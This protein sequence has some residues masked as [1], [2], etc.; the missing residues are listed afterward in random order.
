MTLSYKNIFRSLPHNYILFATNDPVYTILEITDCFSLSMGL[1]GVDVVGKGLFDAFP[2]QA[3]SNARL[4]AVSLRKVIATKRMDSMNVVRY[5]LP[6]PGGELSERYWKP[7]N[8]PFIGKDGEV[9]ILIHTALDITK[10]LQATMG[11]KINIK[12]EMVN[13]TNKQI[14][15]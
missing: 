3:D 11:D 7:E 5:D 8:Y 15:Y 2:D 10:I 1:I 4:L 12:N 6:M 13:Q 14:P 9:E